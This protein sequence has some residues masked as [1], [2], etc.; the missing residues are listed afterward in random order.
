MYRAWVIKR[1]CGGISLPWSGGGW[2]G[3]DYLDRDSASR[4]SRERWAY[5]A[6]RSAAGQASLNSRECAACARPC[7]PGVY[8][9]SAPPS[10]AIS[11]ARSSADP[12]RSALPP[13]FG[14]PAGCAISSSTGAGCDTTRTTSGASCASSTGPASGPAGGR[15]SATRRPSGVGRSAAGRRL[16]KSAL[17]AAHDHL[18]RRKRIERATASGADLGAARADPGV[19]V[20]LQLEGAV[21]RRRSHL[22]EL[23]LP[24]LSHDHPCSSAGGLGWTAGAPGARGQRLHPC[25]AGPARDRVAAG[26]RSGTQSGRVHLGSLETSRAAQLL[27]A[28]FRPAQLSG[29]PRPAPHA[30]ASTASPIV[31]AASRTVTIICRTQ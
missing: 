20:S 21:G 22:V 13:G 9:S 31:L 16:K 27:P 18:H 25:A 12:R 15:W 5:I 29:L 8:P 11:S 17:R 3:R 2:R 28:R 23:L 24:S 1:V 26:L 19:A 14:P 30:P 4:R 7:T 6:S 10:C